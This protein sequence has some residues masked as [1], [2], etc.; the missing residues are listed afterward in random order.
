MT[1][2]LVLCTL[3]IV[4]A[5]VVSACAQTVSGTAARSAPAVDEDSRSP[6]DVDTV[7]LT[8]QQMQAVTG[9]GADLTAV[10]GMESK[11][12]VDLTMVP[13]MI[14]QTLVPECDW[15][16]DETRVF[17]SQVEEFHKVS[18]Q[19]PARGALISQAAA[20]YRDADTATTHLGRPRRT[21]RTVPCNGFGVRAGRR[22]RRS[23]GMRCASGRAPAAAT[24]G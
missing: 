10:P 13:G 16:F 21:G 24:T 9:S 12:P 1:G 14:A 18:Y 15:V 17:G 19:N 20:G 23:P 8:Q 11:A 2:R 4:L 22:T 3:A 6:V 7:L 5:I